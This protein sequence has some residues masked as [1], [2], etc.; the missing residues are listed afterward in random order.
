MGRGDPL[1]PLVWTKEPPRED[2]PHWGRSR[3][4]GQSEWSEPFIITGNDPDE[5]PFWES[6]VNKE[7]E[8]QFSGPIPE[9][10]DPLGDGREG[11]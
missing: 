5:T 9:P 4:I 8:F 1:T 2:K 10:T 7:L 6:W 11:E 3:L